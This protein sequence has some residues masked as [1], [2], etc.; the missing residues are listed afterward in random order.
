MDDAQR[1]YLNAIHKMVDNTTPQQPPLKDEVVWLE[2]FKAVTICP[3]K[4]NGT[5]LEVT[6]EILEAFKKRFRE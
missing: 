4:Y 1:E 6:D 5:V 3:H 2:I